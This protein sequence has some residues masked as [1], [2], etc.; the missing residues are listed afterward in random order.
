MAARSFPVN[1]LVQTFQSLCS[2]GIGFLAIIRHEY[3]W[4]MPVCEGI[5]E[6]SWRYEH[7]ASL[8]AV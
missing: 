8:A 1:G 3:E 6:H 2:G 4:D 5:D 7:G